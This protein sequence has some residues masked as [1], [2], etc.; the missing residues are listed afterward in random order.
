MAG[1]NIAENDRLINVEEAFAWICKSNM[2]FKAKEEA[3]GDVKGVPPVTSDD[4][5][6]FTAQV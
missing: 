3:C 4:I 6:G 1:P 2:T 5:A